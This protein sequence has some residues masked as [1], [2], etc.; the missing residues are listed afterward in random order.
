MD[1]LSKQLQDSILSETPNVKWDDVA[2]LELAKSELQAAIIFT[3]RFPQ[4]FRDKR[5]V[6]PNILL[7]GPPGTGKSHLAK[8]VA[9]KVN[10]TIFTINIHKVISKW[11]GECE[12]L[13]RQLFRVARD[14]KPS[15]IF[16]DEIDAISRDGSATN[17]EHMRQIRTEFLF[18]VDDVANKNE[19]VLILAATNLPWDLDPPVRKRFRKRIHIP[20]PDQR[21]REELFKVHLGEMAPMLVDNKQVL[22]AL[23]RRTGGYSGSD[24][25]DLVQDALMTPVK[26]AHFATHIRKTRGRDGEWYTP[27]SPDAEGETPIQWNQVPGHQLKEPPLLFEDFYDAIK[28]TKPS[29]TEEEVRKCVEW[30]QEYGTE[31][32]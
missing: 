9:T 11:I 19:G 32:V 22:D 3:L 20:L 16:L 26:G 8:A 30:T 4:M 7:Y 5:Q 24:I 1:K 17:S 2:G 13:I 10:R 18:Q 12:E 31:G 23:A 27:R 25:A 14:K 15:I 28:R 29:V 6:R 21:S